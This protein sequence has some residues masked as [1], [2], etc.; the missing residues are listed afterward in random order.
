MRISLLVGVGSAL[1]AAVLGTLV[2]L[3]AAYA[4]GKTDALLMRLVDLL[5]PKGHHFRFVERW[6]VDDEDEPEEDE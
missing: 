2:G 5:L 1:I 4:G 6:L 3:L